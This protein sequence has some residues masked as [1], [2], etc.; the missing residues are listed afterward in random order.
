MKHLLYAATCAVALLA[1]TSAF[2]A[3]MQCGPQQQITTVYPTGSTYTADTAGIVQS[4]D[5]RDVNSLHQSGCV[6]VGVGNGGLCGELLA[7]NMNV[8]GAGAVGDQ[9]FKWFVGPTQSYQLTKI[10]ARNASRS[11]GSGSAA[12]GIYTAAAKGGS[13]VVAANQ[14]YTGLTNSSGTHTLT[15]TLVSGVGDT[16]TYVN[17]PL[18]FS[19]TTADGTAGH[20]DLFA[21]CDMGN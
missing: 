21:Y 17:S 11:F 1:T 13:A 2:A 7:A 16:D 3:T 6:Q 19:L 9:P 4:V 12:G 8:G 10:V 15:L 5:A 20:L 18:F 14:A